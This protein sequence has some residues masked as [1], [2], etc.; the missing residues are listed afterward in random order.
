MATTSELA[1]PPP[2]TSEA[3][4]NNNNKSETPDLSLFSASTEDEP[5]QMISEDEVARSMK[6]DQQSKTPYSDATQV[7]PHE[8]FCTIFFLWEE[9]VSLSW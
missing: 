8:I 6:V 1:T 9:D 2:P 7:R 3:I 4:V 5:A